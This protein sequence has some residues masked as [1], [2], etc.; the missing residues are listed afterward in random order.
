MGIHRGPNPVKD[1]LVFGYD[2]GY[3]VADNDTATRFY[4]GRPTT[5]H[6][7]AS[8]GSWGT[9][10]SAERIATGNYYNGQPTY[11]CRTVVGQSYRGID[12]TVSGLRTSAG[13]SG[14]VTMSCMVRNNNVSAYP[15]YAYIGYDFTSTRTIA[16]GSDWQRIQWTVNQSS[17]GSDYVEF[18]PYTNNASIYLEMTMPQV[19]VNVGTA[20]PWTDTSR[21]STASLIDLKKTTDIDVSNVS[22]DSTGQPD[23]DGTSDYIDLPD[24]LITNLHG[25]TEASICIWIK[26]DATVNGVGT[27]GIVQLSNYNSSNGCLWFYNNGYT[28]LDIFRT[29][30]VEQVFANNTEVSTNWNLLTVTTAPGANGWKCYM[31]GVLKKQVT[32]D[33]TVSV[34]N[35]QGGLTLG[36]NNSSRYTNGKIAACQIYNRALTAAEVK[37]NYNAHKNRFDI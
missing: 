16:A 34:A 14:T 18:R 24:S 12:T 29:S 30:R 28:Y 33:S 26:N 22:F 27:S 35:I 8:F 3:G 17:M 19:E 2:T 11:N 32:G 36:R 6:G 37:Q 9:E 21:S 31:N 23:F 20:T 10:G 13:S 25:G 4:P 1:G 5:N 7:P 15:M